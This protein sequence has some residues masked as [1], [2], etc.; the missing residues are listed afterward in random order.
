MTEALASQP[1]RLTAFASG[2]GCATKIGQADLLLLLGGWPDAGDPQVV[3]GSGT[4][5]DAAVLRL[6]DGTHLVLTTDFFGPI[7]DD[8]ADFGAIAAANALSD[9]YAMGGTPLAA[10]NLVAWPAED[11]LPHALLRTVLDAARDVV[12]SAGAFVVGGHS[13]TDPEPKFGLAGVGTVDPE[14]LMRNS[15]GA[16][17]DVLLLTKP[18]G[19]GIVAN[20][21]KRD[22]VDAG[23]L[24]AAIAS[25]R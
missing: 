20:A 14:Q 21:H 7:V 17:G 3:V 8:P 16:P 15:S 5:D 25:M 19:T 2:G 23:V 9:V 18:L 12:T 4:G 24:A 11:V 10:L 22:E 13:V 6:R 1:V